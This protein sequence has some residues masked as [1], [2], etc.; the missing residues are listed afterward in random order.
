MVLSC[1]LFSSLDNN[2]KHTNAEQR[3]SRKIETGVSIVSELRTVNISH[4]SSHC[5]CWQAKNKAE[6]II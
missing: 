1:V 5:D 3:V 2:S 6:K 4:Q